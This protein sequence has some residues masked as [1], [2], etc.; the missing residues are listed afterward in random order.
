MKKRNAILAVFI[1][2]AVA[3]TLYGQWASRPVA[4]VY[5]AQRGTAI[6]AVYGT[7]KVVASLTINVRARSSGIIHFA[8]FVAT[9]TTTGLDVK[10]GDL[11][12]TIT[13]EDLEREIAKAEADLSAS[14]ERQRLGP[15]TQPQLNTQ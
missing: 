12:A 7:V 4:E 13:N 8:D 10:Q 6:S 1:L 2:L 5:V 15:P 9:N 14:E 11:L 3:A